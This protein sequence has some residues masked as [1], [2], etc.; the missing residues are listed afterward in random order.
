MWK[1][2]PSPARARGYPAR[3]P[4]GEEQQRPCEQRA[5]TPSLLQSPALP[6]RLLIK[7]KRRRFR[8]FPKKARSL[9]GS[10]ASPG[11]FFFF[12]R[13]FSGVFNAAGSSRRDPGRISLLSDSRSHIMGI[14]VDFNILHFSTLIHATPGE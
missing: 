9:L 6:T 1:R 8:S 13:G 4:P 3:H 7:R 11:I 2:N 10:C 14:W 12:I 5:E